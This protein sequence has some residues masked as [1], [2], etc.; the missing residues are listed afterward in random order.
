V[1][2]IE[3]IRKNWILHKLPKIDFVYADDWIGMYLD[4]RLVFER[5]SMDEEDVLNALGVEYS[6]HRAHDYLS[7][8]GCCPDDLSEVKFDK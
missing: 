7:E 6:S 1:K 5:H 8:R 4:G 3:E 2:E